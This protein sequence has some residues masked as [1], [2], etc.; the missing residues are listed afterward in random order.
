MPVRTETRTF[1]GKEFRVVDPASIGYPKHSLHT[2]DD[3]EPPFLKYWPRIVAGETVVDV[4]A[5]MGA[6]AL[7]ALA[8]GAHVIA[9]EP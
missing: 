4:G 9:Y 2:F 1:A 6:Y 3:H 8:V 7:P 5:C